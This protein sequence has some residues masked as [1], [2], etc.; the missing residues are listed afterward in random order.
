MAEWKSTTNL[1][2]GITA[3]IETVRQTVDILNQV[4]A[5]VDQVNSFVRLRLNTVNSLLGLTVPDPNRITLETLRDNIKAY[6]R[7]FV[8]EG[9]YLLPLFPFVDFANDPLEHVS[10]GIQSFKRR[11]RDSV[12][13]EQDDRRPTFSSSSWTAGLIV[14]VD[15]QNI[16]DIVSAMDVFGRIFNLARSDPSLIAPVESLAAKAGSDRIVLNWISGKGL[17]PDEFRIYRSDAE[18]N[19]VSESML[20]ST[21]ANIPDTVM[22]YADTTVVQNRKYIYTVTPY[23]S[24][25][26]KSASVQATATSVQGFGNID[27]AGLHACTNL[28]QEEILGTR[29]RYCLVN[30]TNFNVSGN[31]NGIMC[32]QG[33]NV[34]TQYNNRK[35][36]YNNGVE[37]TSTGIT[38]QKLKIDDSESNPV[39]ILNVQLY[40]SCFCQN[41]KNAQVCDGYVEEVIVRNGSP[42]NWENTSI[43]RFFPS[44]ISRLLG[45]VDGFADGLFGMTAKADDAVSLFSA[46][47]TDATAELRNILV[48]I[49]DLILEIEDLFSLPAPGMY[50]L[51][52]PPASGGTDQ[53]ILTMNNASG[54]PVSNAN[55]Y[56][57][58]FVLLFGSSVQA[59]VEAAYNIWK[60]FISSV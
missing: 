54:G 3:P 8:S 40:N 47:L 28:V 7:D 14:A 6:L 59:E 15:S 51:E 12:S 27:S 43:N 41:G 34:C 32:Y 9:V 58:G 45:L 18:G 53:F 21:V 46:R 23:F 1:L 29:T 60:I 11:I 13:D 49:R 57:V 17:T 44:E 25:E 55:G 36:R 2:D 4:I 50:V 26:G 38:V 20:L 35:C 24:V 31:T 56:T 48:G 37:C 19:D 33:T 52:I 5:I 22:R 42:P 30:S 39:T 16:P 10:G